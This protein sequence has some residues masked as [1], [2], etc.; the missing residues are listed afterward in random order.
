[1]RVL[2]NGVF[3]HAEAIDP[4]RH[5]FV[6]RFRPAENILLEAKTDV[7]C[8]CGEVLRFRHNLIDHYNKGCTDVNQYVDI[9][10][11]K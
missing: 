7:L 2:L 4:A 6:G 11:K 3:V 10:V 1:M 9:E 5:K 8:P